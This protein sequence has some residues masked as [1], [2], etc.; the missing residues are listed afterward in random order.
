MKV[1][2]NTI[3]LLILAIAGVASAA[4]QAPG[5][6]KLGGGKFD[7]DSDK[8]KVVVVAIGAR[9]LPLSVP[10]AAAM[11]KLS[12]KYAKDGVSFYFVMTDLL[13]GDPMDASTD[14]QLEEFAK[15]HRLN[16]VV[17]RDPRASVSTK[18]FKTDQLPAFVVLDRNG[19]MSGNPIT[20]IDPKRDISPVVASR[21]DGVK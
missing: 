6:T 13:S 21:I 9:W 16:V 4:A 7:F 20:G 1:L 3:V 15:E 2:R 14:G 5:F 18:L 10:Q 17:L 19:K 11:N 8:G 12:A